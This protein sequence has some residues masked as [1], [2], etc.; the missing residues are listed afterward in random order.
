MGQVD[1]TTK[2]ILALLEQ[3][4]RTSYTQI[5]KRL[6][7]SET[8]VRNRVKALMKEGV[9]KGF[10]VRTCPEKLGKAITALVGVD[11]GGETTPEITDQ[12]ASIKEV[13]DLYVIT[14]EFDLLLRVICENISRLDEILEEIRSHDFVEGTR[15]FVVL[16]KV[17]ESGLS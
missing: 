12:L 7:V 3:D 15:T 14:G 5:A 8:T 11:I 1:E 17:K 4:A 16:R 9:L 6:G 10:T 2:R 13:S